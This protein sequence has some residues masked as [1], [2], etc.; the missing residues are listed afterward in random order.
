MEGTAPETLNFTK[1]PGQPTPLLEFPLCALSPLSKPSCCPIFL[2]SCFYHYHLLQLQRRD[3]SPTWQIQSVPRLF[4][5]SLNCGSNSTMATLT[6]QDARHSMIVF[7]PSARP[8]R[9]A[10]VGKAIQ[11]TNG[12]SESIE[13]LLLRWHERSLSSMAMANC[14]GQTIIPRAKPT[15]S[16]ILLIVNCKL[17]SISVF[18]NHS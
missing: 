4:P 6:Y 3:L 18:Q 9:R 5:Q 17:H 7:G 1:S 2:S 10:K 16:S 15:S 11:F 14:F 8:M 12:E 13:A